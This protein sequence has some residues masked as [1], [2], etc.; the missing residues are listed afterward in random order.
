MDQFGIKLSILI[1]SIIEQLSITLQGT[2]V[3]V[4]DG[5]RAAEITLKS[6]ERLGTD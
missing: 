3:N 1:F 5:F 4:Q 6:I 2:E